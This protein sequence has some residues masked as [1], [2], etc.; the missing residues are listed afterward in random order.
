MSFSGAHIFNI[1]ARGDAY[2]YPYRLTS[3]TEF[4]SPFG[5]IDNCPYWSWLRSNVGNDREDFSVVDYRQVLFRNYA[6]AVA[7]KLR[8]NGVQSEKPQ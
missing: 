5:Y 1:E 7:F 2:Y 8:W 6:D 3:K 4:I